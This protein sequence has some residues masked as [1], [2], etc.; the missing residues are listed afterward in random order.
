VDTVAQSLSE[1]KA[2]LE[3]AAIQYSISIT[4]PTRNTADLDEQC[5]YVI[6]QQINRDGVY[7]LTAAAKMKK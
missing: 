1:A 6:R 5:L 7:Q 2:Q 3:Q 4:R